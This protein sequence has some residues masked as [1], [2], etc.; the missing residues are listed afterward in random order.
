VDKSGGESISAQ[1]KRPGRTAREERRRRVRERE[2]IRKLRERVVV[3]FPHNRDEF[4]GI[5]VAVGIPPGV[6]A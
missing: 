1:H 4:P 5:V 2:E 3:W 6:T